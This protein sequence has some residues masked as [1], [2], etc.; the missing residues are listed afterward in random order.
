MLF[1]SNDIYGNILD[2]PVSSDYSFYVLL[3]AA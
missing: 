2:D 1:H 3:T